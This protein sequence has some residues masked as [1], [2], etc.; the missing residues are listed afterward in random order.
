MKEK[1]RDET[2]EGSAYFEELYKL[3]LW[4]KLLLPFEKAIYL[5]K[6]RLA[7]SRYRRQRAKRGFS[8]YDVYDMQMWFVNTMRPMLAKILNNLHSYPD[9]VT[10]EEWQAILTE[11]I[12]CLDIMNYRDDRCVID[13]DG[14]L[15]DAEWLREVEQKRDEARERFF[16]LY[17]KWFWHIVY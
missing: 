15:A 17:G 2:L 8:D 9:E 6:D 12:E 3:T 14:S 13:H 11:M 16:E 1:E 4:E 10:F 5:V 7:D